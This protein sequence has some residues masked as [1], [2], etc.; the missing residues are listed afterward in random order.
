MFTLIAVFFSLFFIALTGWAITTY[1]VKKD[2]QKFISEEIKHLLDISK[3]FFLSLKNLIGI[4]AKHSFSTHPQKESDVESKE[5]DAQLL[6]L[7]QP[8]QP[9]QPV[10][11]VESPSFEVTV[12]EDTAMSSFSPELIE[13]ITEEE[14]K[15][16]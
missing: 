8:V 6:N 13:V 10:E 4:L 16:A 2:S 15:I 7:V 3:M 12:D 9:V 11:L 5:L 1:L 14:E